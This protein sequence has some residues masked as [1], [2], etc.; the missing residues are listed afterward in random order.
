MSDLTDPFNRI[1]GGLAVLFWLA[2][3]AALGWQ[4]WDFF[5]EGAWHW[6]PVKML[7]DR[8]IG[9]MEMPS[10]DSLQVIL[11]IV[12]SVSLVMFFGFLAMAFSALAKAIE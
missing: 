2:T 5:V 10:S 3:V 1:F 8:L 12:M 11:A 6:I 9:P 4:I 7:S